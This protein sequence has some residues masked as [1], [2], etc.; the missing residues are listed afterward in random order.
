MQ[1]QQKQLIKTMRISGAPYSR[2]AGQVG[3]S[4]NCKPAN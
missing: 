1:E 2:I 3:L 4:I